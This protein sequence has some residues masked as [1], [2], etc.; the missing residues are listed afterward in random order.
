MKAWRKHNAMISA[1]TKQL[2][3]ERNEALG[4]GFDPKDRYILSIDKKLKALEGYVSKDDRK[5]RFSSEVSQP[6][7]LLYQIM[8]GKD[9]KNIVEKIAEFNATMHPNA[10]YR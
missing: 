7:A 5:I 2:N 10:A 6:S 9:W 1:R 3:A 4:L 8:Y